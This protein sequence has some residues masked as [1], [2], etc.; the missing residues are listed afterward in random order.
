MN[1]DI[2]TKKKSEETCKSTQQYF[3][4]ALQQ[5]SNSPSPLFPSSLHLGVGKLYK[6][7]LHT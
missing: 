5:V 4:D 3:D 1:Q 6:E 2:A 7:H